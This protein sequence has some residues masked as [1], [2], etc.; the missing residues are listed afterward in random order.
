MSKNYYY[1]I[2]PIWLCLIGM[3]NAVVAQKNQDNSIKLSIYSSEQSSSVY[4]KQKLQGKKAKQFD[5]VRFLNENKDKK[6]KI[7]GR[8]NSGIDKIKYM[9]NSDDYLGKIKEDHHF[10]QE[11]VSIEK[12]PFLGVATVCEKAFEGV[13]VTRIINETAAEQSKLQVDDIIT[14]IEGV[15][16]RSNCDLS[17]GV[18]SFQVGDKIEITIR[19]MGRQLSKSARLGERFYKTI[20]WKPVQKTMPTQIAMPSPE[21]QLLVFPNPSNGM[22]QMSFASENKQAF[23]I[24]VT[25]INGRTIYQQEVNSFDKK[26]DEYLDLSRE[27]DGLYFITIIQGTQTIKEK[28]IIQKQ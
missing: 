26:H 7:S 17:K 2:I 27:A 19:R 15:E 11:V 21:G 25:D 3:T 23:S 14:H 28:L 20:S 6:V 12:V 22:A 16:I 18:Q 5:V 8:Q 1:V 24:H 9:Y 10:Q 4:E 13:T